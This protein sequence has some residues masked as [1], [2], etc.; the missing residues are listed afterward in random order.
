MDGVTIPAK[1]IIKKAHEKGALVML[2]AAQSAPHKEV[3]VRDLDVD[4]LSCS[5]HKMLGPT[6]TG[7]LYGKKNLLENLK[8]LVVG[9]ET[10]TD[11]TYDKHTLE[12][13]PQRLEPGLQHYAGII[14]LKAAVEYLKKVGLENIGKHEVELNKR[15]SEGLLNNEKVKLIGPENPELRGGIFSFNIEGMTPHSVALMLDTAYKILM[16]SGAH[17]VHSW[18]NKHDL[19][20]S[21]RASLYLYNSLEECDK[22]VESVKKLL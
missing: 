7:V 21:A 14:G 20:G 12:D 9:G 19:P 13:L 8:P 6:A 4:F 3:D 17:C 2:D 18:F 11:S 16:R 10:V 5:G 22:F 1:E 15:I